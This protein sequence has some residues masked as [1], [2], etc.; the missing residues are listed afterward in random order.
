M[1]NIVQAACDHV[2]ALGLQR[3]ALFGTGFTMRV[4]GS[5]C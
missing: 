5:S 3:L 1:L 2:R 4:P